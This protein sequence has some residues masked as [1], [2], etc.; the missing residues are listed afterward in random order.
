MILETQVQGV[1]RSQLFC[2]KDNSSGIFHFSPEDFPGLQTHP[3]PFSSRHGKVLKGYFYHYD[4]P[5][6][7]RVLVFDHGMG[8]GHRAYMREIDLLAKAGFLVF[9]YDH[10]GC[11]ESGGEGTN[12][13]AQSL[14][15]LDACIS[16]LKNEKALNGRTFS[17]I[18]HSWGGFS[19][20]NICALHPDITHVVSLCGFIS[21]EQMINQNFSG[22]LKKYRDSIYAMERSANPAYVDFRAE[23]SLEKTNANVLL[24]YSDNDSMVHKKLHYTVLKKALAEKENIRFLLVRG[25]DHNPTYTADAV[26][27]KNAFF[28][29]MKKQQK[30]GFLQTAAQKQAFMARFDWNRMTAQDDTVWNVILDALKSE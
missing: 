3:Y 25:K 9:S 13:L 2:R 10:T 24:V 15:D 27:Y 18:G 5:I 19:T 30:N 26:K 11:M 22:F 14:S 12:G 6:P 29:K 23:E 16:V 20:M 7:G 21:V 8:N 4:S 28:A 1:Y 17:V